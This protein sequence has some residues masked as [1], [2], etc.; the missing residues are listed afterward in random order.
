MKDELASCLV[1]VIHGG[2]VQIVAVV[3]NSTVMITYSLPRNDVP[4]SVRTDLLFVEFTGLDHKYG[5]LV[6]TA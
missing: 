1:I 6:N 3:M 2:C 5:Y 4:R